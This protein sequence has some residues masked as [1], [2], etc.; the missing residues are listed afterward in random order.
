M[1][2]YRNHSKK[3]LIFAKRKLGAIL[4]NLRQKVQIMQFIAAN[5][6]FFGVET[7][8]FSVANAGKE[9]NERIIKLYP[10]TKFFSRPLGD[11][12]RPKDRWTTC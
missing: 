2:S 6:D 9:P 4:N 10:S 12:A 7:R 1:I 5:N 3:D 8:F 11:F